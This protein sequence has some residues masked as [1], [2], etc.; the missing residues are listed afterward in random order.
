M[1]TVSHEMSESLVDRG[2]LGGRYDGILGVCAGIEMLHVLHEH[3]IQTEF[4]VGVINWTNEE[5]ARFPISMVSSGVW[6]GKIPL[7]KA[8]GLREVGEG[9]RSMKEE[10]QR[11]G[12]FGKMECSYEA[13]PLAAHFELHIEQGPRLEAQNKQIGI[14]EGVQAYRWS[15]ITVRGRDS[16]TGTTD[17]PNRSDALLTAAKMILHSHQLAAERNALASTG[18]LNLEPG[19]TNTVPGWVQFSLDIRSKHDEVVLQLENQLKED[20]ARIATNQQINSI[21]QGGIA[22][23]GCE[24]TWTLDAPSEAVKFDPVCIGCAK[25]SASDLF[26][27]GGV[28]LMTSGA[29]HDSVGSALDASPLRHTTWADQSSR[30]SQVKESQLV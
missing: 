12:Y 21:D 20:F 2:D 27:T 24:V 10:L 26:G 11:I 8:H 17:F 14:V 16:H 15:T 5:G 6:A 25:N 30:F 29:G 4:P 7:E 22:G 18:I 1:R 13:M 3:K 19:S 28:E 9:K 23:K